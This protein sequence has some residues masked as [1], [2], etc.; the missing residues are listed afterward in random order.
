VKEVRRRRSTRGAGP[1]TAPATSTYG[2]KPDWSTFRQYFARLEKQGIG[3]NVADYVGATQVRRV[4]LGDD[5]RAPTPAELEKMKDLVR[6]AMR[7]GAVGLSTAL[8]Y[9]RPPTPA[10]GS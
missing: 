1:P 6:A 10:P 4:V 8:Q 5:N 9:A 7:D 3:I 2:I